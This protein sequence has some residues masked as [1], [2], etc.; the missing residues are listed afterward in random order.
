MRPTR[1]FLSAADH[2]SIRA[3]IETMCAVP[4]PDDG[5]LFDAR[6]LRIDTIRLDQPDGGLRARLPGALGNIRLSL[7][8]DIVFG[9]VVTPARELRNYPTLLDLPAP[10]LWTYPREAMVAEKFHAMVTRGEIKLARQGPLGH[11]LPRAPLRVRRRD[12]AKRHRGDI[13]TPRDL[14]HKRQAAGAAFRLLRTRR[15]R[16]AL[17]GPA[18]PDC[19]GRRRSSPAR[20]CGRGVAVLPGTGLRQP[21]RRESVHAGLARWRAVAVGTAGSDGRRRR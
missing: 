12:P 17:A 13:P 15:A 4:C 7:Q 21:D 1:D 16:A 6:A 14:V 10:R 20:G 3:A 8:M 9:D 18:P 11:R 2:T 19:D 5:V